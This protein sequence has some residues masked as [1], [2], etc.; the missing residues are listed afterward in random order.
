MQRMER[1]ANQLCEQLIVCIVTL[2]CKCRNVFGAQTR[3]LTSTN[4][5]FN[6][7]SIRC[8]SK[9][10]PCAGCVSQ[11]SENY[12]F[13]DVMQTLC[14]CH[15]L[16]GAITSWRRDSIISVFTLHFIH[17]IKTV[18]VIISKKNLPL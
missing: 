2:F 1:I 12:G 13:E 4:K 11:L 10:Y 14:P 5:C 3:T 17:N 16:H 9:T 7:V 15:V 8:L 6:S 18:N